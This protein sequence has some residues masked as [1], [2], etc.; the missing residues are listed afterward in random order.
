M[1]RIV[2]TG[3]GTGG[4]IYPLLAVADKLKSIAGTDLE[5]TYLGPRSAFL[6]EFEERGIAIHT[7]AGS[8]LRR[9]YGFFQNLLDVPRFFIG[10]IQALTKLYLLMPDVVFSKGGPG[11][12]AVVLAARFYLVPVMIHES[13]AVPGL[14]SRLSAPFARRI[15]IAFQGAARFFPAKK[16]AFVGNPVRMGLRAGVPPQET[17]RTELKF[18]SGEPLLLVLGGSQG[19]APL[20]AFVVDNLTT[21]L[22]KFQVYHQAGAANLPEVQRI[23]DSVL[24]DAGE[25]FK[26]RYRV[27]GNLDDRAL[28]VALSAA[29]IVLSRAGAGSIYEIATFGK[30]ALLVPLEIDG[31]QQRANAYEYAGSG[32]ATVIEQKN[33]SVNLF[34]NMAAHLLENPEALE[35]ARRAAKLFWKPLAADVIAKELLAIAA[36]SA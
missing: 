19:A 13:D 1:L 14:T 21:L 33:L 6:E 17:A 34:L 23:T 24:R 31:G 15:G 28:G 12:L 26:P 16:T 36:R 35:A 11:A 25:V 7:V 2:L 20:N 30:P 18:N 22:E 32:A 5:L 4:H 29:D 8:K 27:A 9:G 10:I 3:G